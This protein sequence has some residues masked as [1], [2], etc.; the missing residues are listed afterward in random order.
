MHRFIQPCFA[1]GNLS[2]Y[3]YAIAGR[4]AQQHTWLHFRQ[5]HAFF[6][7]VSNQARVGGVKSSNFSSAFEER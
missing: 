5:W 6:T 2:I 7:F 3:R 4:Q 1:L